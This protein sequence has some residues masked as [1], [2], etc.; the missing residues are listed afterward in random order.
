MLPLCALIPG[1]LH[2]L[3]SG[4]NGK[5]ENHGEGIPVQLTPLQFMIKTDSPIPW[6]AEEA[7]RPHD[8][9]FIFREGAAPVF[10]TNEDA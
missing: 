2:F 1:S 6:K 7:A 8:D 3:L 10:K 9:L 4:M 5:R